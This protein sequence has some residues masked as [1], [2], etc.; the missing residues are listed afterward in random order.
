M[1]TKNLG[2]EGLAKHN[3]E[4]E[5]R[6]GVRM[7]DLEESAPTPSIKS[8][9]LTIN[10]DSDIPDGILPEWRKLLAQE[11]SFEVAEECAGQFYAWLEGMRK[12]SPFVQKVRSL[13]DKRGLDMDRVCDFIHKHRDS[14]SELTADDR[15]NLQIFGQILAEALEFAQSH[16][17]TDFVHEKLDGSSGPNFNFEEAPDSIPKILHEWHDHLFPAGWW[18]PPACPN[19]EHSE[20]FRALAMEM[21]G[22]VL[23]TQE[24]LDSVPQYGTH[25]C[26]ALAEKREASDGVESLPW[27]EPAGMNKGLIE[28]LWQPGSHEQTES[29]A[30]RAMKDL[31]PVQHTDLHISTRRGKTMCPN[32]MQQLE[33]AQLSHMRPEIECKENS[34][35]GRF[36]ASRPSVDNIPRHSLGNGSKLVHIDSMPFFIDEAP[37][38]AEL[39]LQTRGLIHTN[40]EQNT[41]ASSRQLR[42]A[43]SKGD[44]PRADMSQSDWDSNSD[45]GRTV[46]SKTVRRSRARNKL[47]KKSRRRNR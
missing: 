3:Q 40:A 41:A 7:V 32:W 37:V 31:T 42:A 1:N 18:L 45:S 30:L 5:E 34:A 12:A 8:A 13:C 36:R 39:K 20:A 6:T 11:T 44:L 28:G 27:Q 38:I 15:A 22:T 21:R 19:Q 23:S 29:R 9:R 26:K 46:S 2:K 16:K 17:L 4:I 24:L 33:D 14:L 10:V 43:E 47:A 35:H 25:D